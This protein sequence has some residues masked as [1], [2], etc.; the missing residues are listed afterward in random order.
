MKAL[1][2][3]ESI[4]PPSVYI[5]SCCHQRPS[6][7]AR[8]RSSAQDATKFN[9]A[10]LSRFSPENASNSAIRL[11]VSLIEVSQSRDILTS[12]VFVTPYWRSSQSLPD[13]LSY[14]ADIVK[15]FI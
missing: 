10:E 14:A 8:R 4:N 7:R 5:F 6:T 3:V 12:H 1:D 11:S 9:G 15:V 13:T 2:G